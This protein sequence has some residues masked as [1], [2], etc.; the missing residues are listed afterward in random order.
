M[1][2]A[3]AMAN[4][5]E[6]TTE[7]P[8]ERENRAEVRKQADVFLSNG[9]IESFKKLIPTMQARGIDPSIYGP[10]YE[11]VAYQKELVTKGA[12]LG[13]NAFNALISPRKG[14]SD[15][16]ESTP[17]PDAQGIPPIPQSQP[18]QKESKATRFFNALPAFRSQLDLAD[19]EVAKANKN[20]GYSSSNR[21]LATNIWWQAYDSLITEDKMQPTE[22]ARKAASYFGFIPDDAASVIKDVPFEERENLSRVTINQNMLNPELLDAAKNIIASTSSLSGTSPQKLVL[23]DSLMQKAQNGEIIPTEYQALFSSILGVANLPLTKEDEQLLPLVLGNQS[24]DTLT[25]EKQAVALKQVRLMRQETELNERISSSN[26][27]ARSKAATEQEIISNTPP[28]PA[29]M[30]EMGRSEFPTDRAL[31]NP[32]SIA[33]GIALVSSMSKLR[34]V[35]ERIAPIYEIVGGSTLDRM[36]AA[37]NLRMQAALGKSETGKIYKWYMDIVQSTAA[38]S[39]AAEL[40]RTDLSD[41]DVAHALRAFPGVGMNI[42]SNAG[43]KLKSIDILKKQITTA[44]ALMNAVALPEGAEKKLQA[45]IAETKTFI[46][47]LSPPKNNSNATAQNKQASAQAPQTPQ[48]PSSPNRQSIPVAVKIDNPSAIGYEVYSQEQ[49]S[50]MREQ[51][52][53]FTKS[54]NIKKSI[55]IPISKDIVKA[56]EGVGMIS[57]VEDENGN[58][59]TGMYL[60]LDKN[61]EEV[62]VEIEPKKRS[63]NKGKK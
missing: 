26:A 48:A 41:A 10:K 3:Q 17:T 40:G 47:K 31:A 61:N 2:A 15:G 36:T 33:Q 42:D 29:K 13:I 11:S 57:P 30:A 12:Q 44:E 46:N 25:N 23:I 7:D 8:I 43:F 21:P 55:N 14:N 49:L 19:K 5:N 22:A 34:D 32:T 9:D 53:E 38:T 58:T 16:I 39:A 35:F 52:N 20:L 18:A 51:L 45:E 62:W 27:M 6:K 28:T 60:G 54:H 1:A 50:Y 56:D 24:F 37:T 4:S 59:S 63:K